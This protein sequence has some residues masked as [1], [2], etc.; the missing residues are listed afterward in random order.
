MRRVFSRPCSPTRPRGVLQDS[1]NRACV[2]PARLPPW[3]EGMTRNRGGEGDLT[4][5]ANQISSLVYEILSEARRKGTERFAFVPIIVPKPTFYS[6]L[7]CAPRSP[8]KPAV[9][10]LELLTCFSFSLLFFPPPLRLAFLLPLFGN[11]SGEGIS[12]GLVS[13]SR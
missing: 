13:L 5:F 7:A 12:W 9:S 8:F 1:I 10:T 2:Y 6:G 3:K 11:N 4:E